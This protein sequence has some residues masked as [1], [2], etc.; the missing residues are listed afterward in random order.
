MGPD[1]YLCPHTVLRSITDVSTMS[2][3][4]QPGVGSMRGIPESDVRTRSGLV[5]SSDIPSLSKM[6]TGTTVAKDLA[7]DIVGH[8]GDT[9]LSKMIRKASPVANIHPILGVHPIELH[10][11]CGLRRGQRGCQMTGLTTDVKSLRPSGLSP[12]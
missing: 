11:G 3:P 1:V 4:E 5:H 6:C 8:D 2:P 12:P 9:V 10:A 7:A